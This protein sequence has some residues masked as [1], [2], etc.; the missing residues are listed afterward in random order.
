MDAFFWA[1][2]MWRPVL[3]PPI[4][5]KKGDDLGGLKRAGFVF[6]LVPVFIYG[7]GSILGGLGAIIFFVVVGIPFGA[8]GLGFLFVWG[9]KAWARR[10]A[11]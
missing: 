6:L 9:L 2:A 4:R 11:K 8:L 1:E 10:I 7:A 5:A 3:A